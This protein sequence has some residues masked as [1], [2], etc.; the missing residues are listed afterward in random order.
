MLPPAY[1]GQ[2]ASALHIRPGIAA[3]F[4]RE[5]VAFA[6]A[7]LIIGAERVPVFCPNITNGRADADTEALVAFLT[8]IAG[9]EV[10]AAA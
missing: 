5:A 6:D 2:P 10:E 4:P 7:A 1:A 3:E 8:G 9:P